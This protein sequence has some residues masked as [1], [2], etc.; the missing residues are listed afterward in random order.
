M[1]QIR[2]RTVQLMRTKRGKG[3]KNSKIMWTSYMEGPFSFYC[4]LPHN[5]GESSPL[6]PGLDPASERVHVVRAVLRRLEVG[7]AGGVVQRAN[8]VWLHLP[9]QGGTV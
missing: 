6:M 3:L 7:D 2:G 9:A 8:H 5:V 4:S 1:D